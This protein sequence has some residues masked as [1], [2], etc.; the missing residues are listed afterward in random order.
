MVDRSED[1]K[2]G[3]DV[4]FWFWKVYEVE[5]SNND[6]ITLDEFSTV[7]TYH[8]KE[9][10]LNA[11]EDGRVI[12]C[13]HAALNVVTCTDATASNTPCVLYAFGRKA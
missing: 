5:V 10:V 7:A 12:T 1:G 9:A 13:T 2:K 4:E 11:K 6:T 8:L 3:K